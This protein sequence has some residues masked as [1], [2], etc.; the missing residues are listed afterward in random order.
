MLTRVLGPSVGSRGAC[1][2]KLVEQL[3]LRPSSLFW[4]RHRLGTL[5]YGLLPWLLL[6][7]Q[8]TAV[9]F[10]VYIVS[11]G[12]LS[13]MPNFARGRS[14]GGRKPCKLDVLPQLKPIRSDRIGKLVFCHSF[15]NS[16]CPTSTG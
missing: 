5:C 4:E 7:P 2:K 8:S 11:P 10:E 12:H 15:F 9:K 1:P 14:R 6:L 13:I 3:R 16:S